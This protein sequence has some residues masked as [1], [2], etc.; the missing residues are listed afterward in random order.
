ML[1][2][3]KGTLEIKTKGYI[4]VEKNGIGY[5]IFMPES[6][7]SKLGLILCNLSLATS[8]LGFPTVVTSAIN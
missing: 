3:I 2:Y 8:T 6:T 7:I 5:K 1:A 4:V